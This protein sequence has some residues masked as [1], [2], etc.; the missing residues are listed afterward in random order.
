MVVGG[1]NHARYVRN[2]KPYE[3]YWAAECRGRGRQYTRDNKQTV[4]QA[5]C[6]YA[7]V[8]GVLFAEKQRVERFYEQY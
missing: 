7:K 3:R 2:G 5:Q 6:V 1:E 4:A 8:F